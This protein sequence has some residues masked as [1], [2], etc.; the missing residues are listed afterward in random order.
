V[1]QQ[2]KRGT[3]VDVTPVQDVGRRLIENA[4]RVIVGKPEAIG[5]AVIALLCEGHILAEDVPGVG[6][7]MLARALAGSVGCSFSRLQFTPDLL[8]SDVTGVSVFNQKT[9]EFEFRPGPVMSQV[10][11]ADEINRTSPKTQSALLEAMQ[12]SQVTVDG[13]TY[14][15]MRPFMVLATQNPIE[16]VGTYTLPEAQLDRFMLKI[17]L[18]YPNLNEEMAILDRYSEENPLATLQPVASGQDILW[19]QEQV[20]YVYVS[21]AIKRYIS[22]LSAKTREHPDL[23]LG[24]SPRAS[25]MLMHT[26][27]AEALFSGRDYVLPDDVQNMLLPCWS[28]RLIVKPEGRLKQQEPEMILNQLLREI[29]VP[30]R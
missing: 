12:E 30:E 11:L 5:L 18:G 28:H 17:T 15:L 1:G 23:E 3:H 8:P 10:V 20:R 14:E 22:I 26:A 7:T 19:L 13:Q 16:Q 21:D 24:I 9:Q 4:S 27:K 29:R 2:D 6:K 25:L